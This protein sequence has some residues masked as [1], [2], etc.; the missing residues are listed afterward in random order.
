MWRLDGCRLF[1]MRENVQRRQRGLCT[2]QQAQD[3]EA[4]TRGHT[5]PW[6][7]WITQL[8]EGQQRWA[9]GHYIHIQIHTFLF[10]YRYTYV[11]IFCSPFTEPGWSRWDFESL[12]HR[13]TT[14]IKEPKSR[15]KSLDNHEPQTWTMN[16]TTMWEY[17][18]QREI[19][20]R[21]NKSAPVIAGGEEFPRKK[22]EVDE[23]RFVGCGP[24][25]HHH[26][27]LP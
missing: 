3:T 18:K 20:N 13:G 14:Q 22:A 19:Y 21:G 2:A 25:R 8:K 12:F 16:R 15:V 1:T 10:I 24:N 17:Y 27:I 6:M 7:I 4:G 23:W 9:K 26:T 5:G 11:F